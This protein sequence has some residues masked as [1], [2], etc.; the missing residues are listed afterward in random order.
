[1]TKRSANHISISDASNR[2]GVSHRA[3]RF[4]EERGLVRP[5]NNARQGKEKIRV[6]SDAALDR[7]ATILKLKSFGLTLLE[8][9]STLANPSDGPFGLNIVQCERQIAVLQN[10]L[11]SV[12]DAIAELKNLLEHP[13]RSG[14]D[15]FTDADGVR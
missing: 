11:V 15:Q 2:L 8:I 6:Y 1:M 13:L 7:L 14:R 10:Q 5:K 9:K 4:Y 12:Q 3:L